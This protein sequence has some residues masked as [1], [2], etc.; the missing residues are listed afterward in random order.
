M[1][2]TT[3]KDYYRIDSNQKKKC[4]FIEVNLEIENI[5]KFR[6]LIKSCL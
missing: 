5:E 1:L 6:Y 4:E 3:E 2:V